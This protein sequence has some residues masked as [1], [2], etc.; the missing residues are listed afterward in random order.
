MLCLGDPFRVSRKCQEGRTQVAGSGGMNVLNLAWCL[1]TRR[2][3][4]KFRL[5][6]WAGTRRRDPV[7]SAGGT[8]RDDL[9]DRPRR[10]LVCRGDDGDSGRLDV[11]LARADDIRMTGGL[12]DLEITLLHLHDHRPR[13]DMPARVEAAVG[14]DC[15]DALPD[16]VRVRHRGGRR[17]RARD[18][19]A[20][21][22]TEHEGGENDPSLAAKYAHCSSPPISCLGSPA[23]RISQMPKDTC[24]AIISRS[25]PFYYGPNSEQS[26]SPPGHAPPTPIIGFRL[27]TPLSCKRTV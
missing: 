13:V 14:R 11:G 1:A 23:A 5:A 7:R 15:R 24:Q 22:A 25:I 3:P 16:R 6:V 26:K 12:G 17:H 8:V 19:R 4:G 18:A 10:R 2:A 21:R 27:T 20:D 9:G